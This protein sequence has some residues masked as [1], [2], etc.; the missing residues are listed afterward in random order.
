LQYLA[1]VIAKLQL[2]F[3]GSISTTFGG[4][5]AVWSNAFGSHTSLH[6]FFTTADAQHGTGWAS[7]AG[8]KGV[9]TLLMPAVLL[10]VTVMLQV[11]WLLLWPSYT[12]AVMHA[13]RCI[14]NHPCI[15]REVVGK[16]LGSSAFLAQ[17]RARQELWFMRMKA[18]LRRHPSLWE[19][20][21]MRFAVTVLVV[22]FFFFPSIA[23]VGVGMFAC[24]TVCGASYWVLD[25]TQ[26]CS[27]RS[28]GSVPLAF[29]ADV[30]AVLFSVAL[31]LLIVTVLWTAAHRRLL[32][33]DWF[34]QNFG[35]L[36]SDYE[37]HLDPQVSPGVA[38][39]SRNWRALAHW[40]RQ[41]TSLVWDAVIHLQTMILMFVSVYGMMLHE[42]YQ[43]L[44]LTAV[45]GIY[46]LSVFWVRPFRVHPN[47]QLQAAS[48]A[49][50][51][52]TSLCMMVFVEPA[53]LD[54]QQQEG[55]KTA[56]EATGYVVLAVN[57]LF[58][59]CGVALLLASVV[60]L[61]RRVLCSEDPAVRHQELPLDAAAAVA[62]AAG[63]ALLSPGPTPAEA[64]VAA[65][66]QAAAIQAAGVAAAGDVEITCATDCSSAVQQDVAGVSTQ[67]ADHHM[68]Q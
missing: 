16:W 19:Y 13:V 40:C 7:Q 64:A 43:V 20:L 29:V 50:L 47:Q 49:V 41:G 54:L 48:S 9:I 55:Y 30:P 4:L 34:L 57:L 3:P 63:T 18:R 53:G 61:A 31:P 2:D 23:R 39:M 26:I 32:Q 56:K 42:Y 22:C 1:G 58:V 10:A 21:C 33:K 51:F 24:H 27:L 12:T 66:P 67:S 62:A 6:C 25:M 59:A 45:F 35:F 44:I 5:G 60:H 36:Y 15:K 11:V 46:L 37:V 65:G 52:G 38:L 28:R 8:L 14:I 68:Q 17:P